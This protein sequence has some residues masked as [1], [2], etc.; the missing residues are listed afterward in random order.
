M[1]FKVTCPNVKRWSG[2][3]YCFM[4]MSL[5]RSSVAE[6]LVGLASLGAVLAVVTAVDERSRGYLAEVATNPGAQLA[7]VFG[8]ASRM[9][10][11][12]LTTLGLQAV[13]HRLIVVFGLASLGLVVMMFRT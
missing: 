9:A 13:D 1:T 10:D 7:L 6:R 8:R 11:A 2:T 3:C 4:A 5:S 12:A